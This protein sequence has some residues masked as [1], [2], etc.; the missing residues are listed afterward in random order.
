MGSLTGEGIIDRGLFD[1]ALVNETAIYAAWICAV[2]TVY[3]TISRKSKPGA[4]C[5]EPCFAAT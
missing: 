1:P 4:A 5:T 2:A 3:L